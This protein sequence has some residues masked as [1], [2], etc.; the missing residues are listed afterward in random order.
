MT[1]NFLSVS[2][3]Y[4]LKAVTCVWVWQHSWKCSQTCCS[5]EFPNRNQN[6]G[7]CRGTPHRPSCPSSQRKPTSNPHRQADVPKGS[8]CVWCASLRHGFPAH[9]PPISSPISPL[10]SPY[11]QPHTAHKSHKHPVEHITC[12]YPV[13]Q[14]RHEIKYC[15]SRQ[16]LSSERIRQARLQSLSGCCSSRKRAPCPPV[17]L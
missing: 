12:A 13:P 11:K 8:V 7:G 10:W 16:P 17:W 2:L 5:G 1:F 9:L 14:I 4:R 15:V 6:T 3:W